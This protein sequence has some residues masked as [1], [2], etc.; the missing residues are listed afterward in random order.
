MEHRF[1][2]GDMVCLTVQPF[3]LS[4][5]RRGDAERMRPRHATPR[6][7]GPFGVFQR[8]GG[9]AYELE[10]TTGSQG[11][12]IYHVSCLQRARGPQ[13]TT[14]IELPPLDERGRMLLIPEEIMDVWERRLRSRVI[15]EY[16]VRWRDWSVEDAT[17]ESEHI[18]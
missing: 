11:H 6:L 3:K 12:N 2:I 4:P 18:L 9:E 16:R 5:W 13:V 7:F 14:P 15:R 8:A 1:E 10:L 17:W